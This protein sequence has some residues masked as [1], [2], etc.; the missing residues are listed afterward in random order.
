MAE[1]KFSGEIK[2]IATHLEYK[3]CVES[4]YY[5]ATTYLKV[6]RKPFTTHYTEKEFNE[7]YHR[8]SRN[9]E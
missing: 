6:N 4:P 8:I 5:Y 7:L 3:K 9:Y 2:D 1:K